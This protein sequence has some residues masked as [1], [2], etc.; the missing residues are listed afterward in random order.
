VPLPPFTVHEDVVV[1]DVRVETVSGTAELLAARFAPTPPKPGCTAVWPLPPS[2]SQTEASGTR[3]A[4]GIAPAL[5]LYVRGERAVIDSVVVRYAHKDE[6]TELR[7][8]AVRI[9]LK[10]RP[11]GRPGT[12]TG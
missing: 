8:N 6:Q 3:L 7:W 9:E 4:K 10:P 12:C 2:A 1:S 5:V 11:P